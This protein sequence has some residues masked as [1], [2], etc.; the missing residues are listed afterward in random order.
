MLTRTDRGRR[1]GT[2]TST[3]AASAWRGS[4]RT[5][6]SPE[7]SGIGL[8]SSIIPSTWNSNASA[9]MRR[10]SS[11]VMPAV[12]HPG[13]SG[14]STP[15]SLS[16]CLRSN[17]IYAVTMASSPQFQ[18]GLLLDTAQRPN[19]NVALG[20]RHR[21][22]AR[23]Q[24][25][26]ELMMAALCRDQIPSSRLQC[27]NNCATV[28]TGKLHLLAVVCK[29]CVGLRTPKPLPPS[30]PPSKPAEYPRS[31][32]VPPPSPTVPPL[33]SAAHTPGAPLAVPWP[34]SAPP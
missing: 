13:K 24:W 22:A 27:P 15:K 25:M 2:S 11:R 20:M 8:P 30:S 10:A 18:P 6:S 31:A 32:A 14:N 4:V 29:A 34:R 17:A 1:V 28:H 9:A 5:S 3:A 26:L 12:M 21:D 23:P 19:R 33:R 16:A 7:G